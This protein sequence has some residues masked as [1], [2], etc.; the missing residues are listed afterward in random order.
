MSWELI[1][2]VASNHKPILSF[3]S[4]LGVHFY[5]TGQKS[6]KEKTTLYLPLGLRLSKADAGDGL[7]QPLSE[8]SFS[9]TCTRS[10][11]ANS[12]A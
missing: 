6:D 9:E 1:T 10:G 11:S 4:R 2:T 12:L 8:S 5:P 7:L 3:M